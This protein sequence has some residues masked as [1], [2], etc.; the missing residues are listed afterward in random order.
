V[1]DREAYDFKKE[2]IAAHRTAFREDLPQRSERRRRCESATRALALLSDRDQDIL[3]V[4]L[5]WYDR[6]QRRFLN[7]PSDVI[8]V[9]CDRYSITSD[10]YRQ[11]RDRALK[12]VKAYLLQAA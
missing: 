5:D 3:L 2:Q 10:N 7:V 8:A 4:S 9:L 11:I 6:E 12:R 1:W